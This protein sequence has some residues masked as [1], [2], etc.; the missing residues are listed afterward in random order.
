MALV[1]TEKFGNKLLVPEHGIAF[2]LSVQSEKSAQLILSQRIGTAGFTGS[3]PNPHLS[4]TSKPFRPQHSTDSTWPVTRESR[5]MSKPPSVREQE[6]SNVWPQSLS[7]QLAAP[8]LSP[9]GFP[10]CMAHMLLD[11]QDSTRSWVSCGSSAFPAPAAWLMQL[12]S[13]QAWHLVSFW[14]VSAC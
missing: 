8:S 10:C 13:P 9:G 7:V 12:R 11:I 2:K 3:S 14:E 1:N 6:H 5:A 4:K